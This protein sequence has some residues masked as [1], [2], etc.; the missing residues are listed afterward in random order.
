[1]TTYILLNVIF[2]LLVCLFLRLHGVRFTTSRALLITL[3]GLLALTAVFDN[4]IVGLNIVGYNTNNIL[5]LFIGVAPVE[6]FFYALLAVIVVPAVWH[7]LG[8]K[9]D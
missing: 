6:D 7:R 2:I 3:V 5:G 4:V 9:H 8:P 1:M